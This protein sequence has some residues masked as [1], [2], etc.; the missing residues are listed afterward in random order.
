VNRR[1]PV[2]AQFLFV[3]LRLRLDALTAQRVTINSSDLATL[4][5]RVNVVRVS[6]VFKCPESVTTKD[7]FPSRIGNA[8]GIG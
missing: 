3:V 5:L 1:I 6:R 2:E 8:S 4:C 7:I